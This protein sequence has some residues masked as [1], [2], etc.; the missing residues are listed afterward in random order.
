MTFDLIETNGKYEPELGVSRSGAA[1]FSHQVGG[2]SMM[3]DADELLITGTCST[4]K[5]GTP[6]LLVQAINT[7]ADQVMGAFYINPAA[8][9]TIEK[10]FAD[11]LTLV[12]LP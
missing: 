6:L 10:A 7:K 8:F 9:N 1:G 11:Y 5:H 4:D 3:L 12:M 2:S